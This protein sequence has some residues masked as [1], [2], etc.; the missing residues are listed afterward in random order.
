MDKWIGDDPMEAQ[1]ASYASLIESLHA[2]I[3]S[4]DLSNES[5]DAELVR[6]EADYGEPVY[7]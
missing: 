2:V 6:L 4:I 1:A 3:F 5:L 7:S